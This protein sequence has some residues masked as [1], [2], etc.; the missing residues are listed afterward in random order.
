VAQ[1]DNLRFAFTRHAVQRL[2]DYKVD[3]QEIEGIVAA[4]EWTELQS[5]DGTIIRAYGRLPSRPS[6]V[7]RVAYR[8]E[9]NALVIVITLFPDRDAVSPE[10]KT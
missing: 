4:P 6:Q 9:T 1:N 8:F 7:F 5:G 2:I 3:A 10:R